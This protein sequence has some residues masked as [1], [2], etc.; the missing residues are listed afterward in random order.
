MSD[1]R[2]RTPEAYR[3]VI[4]LCG[5][6]GAGKT[7]AADILRR[8]G[9]LVIPS[10][11]LNRQE[12]ESPEVIE[13]LRAWWGPRV[14]G[15]DGRIDRRQVADI[16]FADP[17]QRRRLE[18]LLHPRIEAARRRMMQSAANDPGVRA[19]VIDAPLLYEAGLDRECDRVIFIDAD[20]A[21]RLERVRQ[22]RGW[23]AEDLDRREQSQWPP[24]AKRLRADFI[25]DNNTDEASFRRQLENV[26]EE[27][28]STAPPR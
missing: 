21:V 15:S 12:L 6:I 2:G 17:D 3:P 1:L 4:G 7:A 28:V 5:G 27:I 25:C 19:F 20:R 11:D 26:F 9:A 8:Q 23:T 24:E 14:V 13:S 18:A 10:D 16:V 22:S